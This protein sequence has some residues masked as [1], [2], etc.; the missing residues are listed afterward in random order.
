MSVSPRKGN[1][2]DIL[3]ALK[4]IQPAPYSCHGQ[5]KKKRK[6]L[7]QR[8]LGGCSPWESPKGWTQLRS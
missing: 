2:N 1:N 5:E 4:E 7:G 3:N 8:S 6:A